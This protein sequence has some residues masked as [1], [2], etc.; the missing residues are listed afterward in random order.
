MQNLA[1][2]ALCSLAFLAYLVCA[3]ALSL[4]LRLLRRRAFR[5]LCGLYLRVPS[6]LVP[7]GAPVWFAVAAFPFLRFACFLAGPSVRS[8]LVRR[9]ARRFRRFVLWSFA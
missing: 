8:P 3:V 6:Y 9:L 1:Y 2:Y 4:A 5:V 7:R